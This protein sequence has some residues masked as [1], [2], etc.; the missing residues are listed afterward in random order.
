MLKLV[1]S[2]SLFM[3]ACNSCGPIVAQ[4]KK[5]PVVI[6][7]Q[8]PTPKAI[9]KAEVPVI[10]TCT[11]A[12]GANCTPV[13]DLTGMVNGDMAVRL[14]EFFK[15]WDNAD[16]Q[17]IVIRINS[18][19]GS[20]ASAFKIHDIIKNAELN[21]KVSCIVDGQAASA[22]FFIL[23]TCTFRYATYMSSLVTHEAYVVL[24]G[25]NVI[26]QSDLI[27]MLGQL[28]SIGN[29]FDKV[30]ADKMGLKI[31]DYQK[32]IAGT[33]WTMNAEDALAARA[34]DDAVMTFESWLNEIRG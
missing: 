26:K 19:G 16:T 28:K 32:K 1:L 25:T 10:S 4:P 20:A 31:T 12:H 9:A 14:G 21:H 33:D 15:S 27:E 6:V 18:P 13:F 2:L 5:P 7:I 34:V 24:E 8:Q 23:Q 29:T 22:A 3:F 17:N 30:I 11:K